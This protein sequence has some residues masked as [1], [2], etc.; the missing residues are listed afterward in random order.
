ME[1]PWEIQCLPYGI[2]W[3]GAFPGALSHGIPWDESSLEAFPSWNSSGWILSRSSGVSSHEISC[4]G[5][6]LEAF[7]TWN[8]LGWS[9]SG[10]SAVSHME[11]HGKELP[12]NS[13]H[14]NSLGWSLSRS[15][16]VSPHGI[17]WDGTF[18]AALLTWNS[19]GWI[20][21]G[22]FSLLEF[23]E[24]EPLWEPWCAPDGIPWDGFSLG[25]FPSWNSL[26]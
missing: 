21:S 16:G 3:D 23:L 6:S 11:F 7:P 19:L 26:G 5:F 20:L 4:D 22:S 10:S 1:P 12:E 14:M 2:L 17:P 15:S 8:S 13:P 25:A 9:L 24:V 18:P